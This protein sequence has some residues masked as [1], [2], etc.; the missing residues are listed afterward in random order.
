LPSVNGVPSVT[1][2]LASAG[3]CEDYRFL[4]DKR[5]FYQERGQA[6]HACIQWFE[7]GTLD[8]ATVHPEIAPGLAAY[9][10]FVEETGYMVMASEVELFHRDY[11]FCGHI[12]S[13]GALGIEYKTVLVD[14]K[15]SDSPDVKGARYQLAGGYRLLWEHNHPDKKVDNCL[16]VALR[17]DGTY[18]AHEVMDDYASQVFLAALIVH[19]ERAKK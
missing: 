7:E 16:V 14:F 19:Q 18:K 4:G 9:R 12:D 11:G 2:V 3:L 10:R 15:Y 13:V 8:E 5:E 6:L 1:E 17:K